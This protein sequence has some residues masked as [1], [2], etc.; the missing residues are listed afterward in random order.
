MQILCIRHSHSPMSFKKNY[1]IFEYLKYWIHKN[2]FHINHTMEFMWFWYEPMKTK[3]CTK[4]IFIGIDYEKL[5]PP[6]PHYLITR[7]PKQLIYNYI[8]IVPWK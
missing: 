7:V 5:C 1:H 8:T 6:Q 2:I 3:I 4:F